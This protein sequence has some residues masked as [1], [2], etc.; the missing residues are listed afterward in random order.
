MLTIKYMLI[1]DIPVLLLPANYDIKTPV[2]SKT[3]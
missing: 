1:T 2:G 3:I